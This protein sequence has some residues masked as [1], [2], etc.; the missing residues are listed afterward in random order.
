MYGWDNSRSLLQCDLCQPCNGWLRCSF[1]HLASKL[2]RLHRTFQ[3]FRREAVDGP[4]TCNIKRISQTSYLMHRIAQYIGCRLCKSQHASF[5][6]TLGHLSWSYD[7]QLQVSPRGIPLLLCEESRKTSRDQIHP[8]HISVCCVRQAFWW[9]WS[10][11]CY[12]RRPFASWLLLL[13]HQASH[14]PHL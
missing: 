7:K 6:R 4:Q 9:C 5:G 2:R 1:H 3:S 13:L 12:M 14:P 11:A 8:I 10:F